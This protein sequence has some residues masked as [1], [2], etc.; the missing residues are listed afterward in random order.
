MKITNPRQYAIIPKKHVAPPTGAPLLFKS[1]RL[2]ETDNRWIHPA[3][4]L[5][6][7]LH[8]TLSDGQI[9]IETRKGEAIA[10]KKI[11]CL[12]GGEYADVRWPIWGCYWK[13][14]RARRDK[15][16]RDYI[17]VSVYWFSHM[18]PGSC[19]RYTLSFEQSDT[20][21]LQGIQVIACVWEYLLYACICV[22]M[23]NLLSAD[24]NR[25]WKERA[26]MA[27]SFNLDIALE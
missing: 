25:E 26:W 9:S 11:L 13:R 16:E 27:W 17:T 1:N 19:K 24:N 8:M 15:D 12:S 18:D 7:P 23:S 6:L 5:F 4:G 14:E 20:I 10:G 22:C 2:V 3:W 21:C